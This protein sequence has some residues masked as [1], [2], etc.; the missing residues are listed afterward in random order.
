[1][2]IRADELVRAAMASSGVTKP[3]ELATKLELTAYASPKRV[4]RWLTGDNKPDYDATIALLQLAGWLNEGRVREAQLA[5]ARR[6]AEEA[7]GTTGALAER[8]QRAR[9]KRKPA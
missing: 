2:E 4:S 5:E 6:L 8:E 9:E 7:A 1:V 3:A